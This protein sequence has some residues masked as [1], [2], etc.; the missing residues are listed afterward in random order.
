MRVLVVCVVC[1]SCG[2]PSLTLPSSAP[3]HT[4]GSL[5][6]C[7]FDLASPSPLQPGGLSFNDVVRAVASFCQASGIPPSPSNIHQVVQ[8]LQMQLRAMEGEQGGVSGE[9]LGG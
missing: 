1:P 4:L 6:A 8:W 9:G 3:P 2:L 5:A 7:P